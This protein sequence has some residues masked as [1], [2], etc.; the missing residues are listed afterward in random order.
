[1]IQAAETLSEVIGAIYDATLD[2]SL[3]LDALRKSTEFVGG[4]AAS[5]YSKNVAHKTGSTVL[6]WNSKPAPRVI[7]YYNEYVKIDPVTSGQFQFDIGQAYSIEDC[8][9]HSE[10]VETRI[11]QEWA[12]PQGWVD[13]LGVTLEKSATS[14][15][16]FGIFRDDEQGL[17]DGE[18]RRRMQS[19]IPHIRRTVLIGNLLDLGSAEATAFVNTLDGLAAG[20]F[21]VD[22][23]A[24]IAFANAS[25][26]AIL[27]EGEVLLRRNDALAPVDPRAGTT[28]HNV[29]ASSG[30]GDASV[31][32]KGIAIPLTL[33]PKDIWLAHVLPLTSG[34]RKGAGFTYSAIA[35]V[36]VH[37]ASIETPSAME[38]MAKSYKLTP[39]EMR[40]LAAVSEIGP[41][42]TV[43]EALGI[44]EATVKTHLQHLF[45]KTGIK[46][47]AELVKLVAAN[48]SPLRKISGNAG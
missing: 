27:D 45:A 11:Y 38:T 32:V 20:V 10:F 17:V 33:P 35:A 39:A 44:S 25:G 23:N 1:M 12:R 34:A 15:S 14:F 13:H 18:M 16:V 5:L 43:A 40:V 41:V 22:K 48:A 8:L 31:G 46:R 21:L 42:S 47:Q 29:I 30:G 26:Q 7:D 24:R 9:P 3:W 4:S 6:H 28:L 2:R 19:I 36:F 37:K